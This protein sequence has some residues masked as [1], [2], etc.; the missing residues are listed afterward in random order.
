MKTLRIVVVGSW[1]LALSTAA[2]AGSWRVAGRYGGYGYYGGGGLS[3]T[4]GSRG[5]SVRGHSGYTGPG[6]G[7]YYGHGR[8]IGYYIG[9]H[10]YRSPYRVWVPR[11]GYWYYPEGRYPDVHRPPRPIR[12]PYRYNP[13]HHYYYPYAYP[14]YGYPYFGYPYPYVGTITTGIYVKSGDDTGAS[15]GVWVVP[16]SGSPDEGPSRVDGL[17]PPPFPPGVENPTPKRYDNGQARSPVDH[18]LAALADMSHLANPAQTEREFRRLLRKHPKDA[19][20]YYANA[21]VFFVNEKY[22]PGALMLRR[23]LDLNPGM[24]A[25]GGA[26]LAGFYDARTAGV[27]LTRLNAHVD[28]FG[29][30]REAR[31]L[32]AYVHFIE[33]RLE[34]ARADLDV[35][36]KSKKDDVAAARLMGLCAAR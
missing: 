28:G 33:G 31:L 27:A 19:R 3:F 35:L 7:F 25:G 20:L 6:R 30:D 29:T 22:L 32:R 21:W 2:W 23:A 4:V 1:V 11:P 10:G 17:T 34:A 12:Y 18:R 9:R 5:W 24:G 16:G 14:I 36:L 13:Y 8:P 15:P 26:V